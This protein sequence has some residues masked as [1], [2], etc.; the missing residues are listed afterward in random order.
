M[1]NTKTYKAIVEMIAEASTGQ[2]KIMKQ[3]EVNYIID[4]LDEKHE[5]GEISTHDARALYNLLD[6]IETIEKWKALIFEATEEMFSSRHNEQNSEEERKAYADCY[7]TLLGAMCEM[8]I[9][10]EWRKKTAN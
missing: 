10:K 8:G 5:A 9:I 3:N 2:D 7:Y 1:T 6:S 4:Y